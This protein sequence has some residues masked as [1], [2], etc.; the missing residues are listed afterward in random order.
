MTG[1][2]GPFWGINLLLWFKYGPQIRTILLGSKCKQ[3]AL[4]DKL[5]GSDGMF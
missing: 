2:G 4:T 1:T 5:F 3:N